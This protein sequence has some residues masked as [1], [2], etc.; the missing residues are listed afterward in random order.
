MLLT[1]MGNVKIIHEN[2]ITV[3]VHCS[4]KSDVGYMTIYKYTYI[5]IYDNL[6]YFISIIIYGFDDCKFS[7]SLYIRDVYEN[8][9]AG[10]KTRT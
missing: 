8:T 5:V 6:Q 7:M 9:F 2:I 10:F 1:N 3:A 4:R